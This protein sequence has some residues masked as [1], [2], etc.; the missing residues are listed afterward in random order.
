MI[1]FYF[2]TKEDEELREK[3]KKR[4][5]DLFCLSSFLILTHLF[6]SLFFNWSCFFYFLL[7]PSF[8]LYS[9]PS[10]LLFFT[11][12]PHFSSISSF[13]LSRFF[14]PLHQ[15]NVLDTLKKTELMR[16]SIRMNPYVLAGLGTYSSFFIFFKN[17]I[18][19]NI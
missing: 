12:F 3:K 6:H 18:M 14:C 10:F 15:I 8:H 16:P 5:Y 17:K 4:E 13:S 11:L 2:K 19:H 7:F 9:S 1:L